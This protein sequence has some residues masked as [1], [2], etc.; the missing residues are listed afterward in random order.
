MRSKKNRCS[1]LPVF[2]SECTKKEVSGSLLQKELI[3][4]DSCYIFIGPGYRKPFS[5]S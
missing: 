4:D 5:V 2:C 3:F 1:E